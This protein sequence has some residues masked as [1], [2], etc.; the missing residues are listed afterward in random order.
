MTDLSFETCLNEEAKV[1]GEV[2]IEPSLLS[3]Y[4]NLVMVAS[5]FVERCWDN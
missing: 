4:I 5:I 3:L 1:G 2:G